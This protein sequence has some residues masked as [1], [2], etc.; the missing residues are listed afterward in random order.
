MSK[1][2]VTAKQL[3]D[4]PLILERVK[5][6]ALLAVALEARPCALLNIP[7]DLPEGEKLAFEVEHSCRDFYLRAVGEVDA[8]RKLERVREF[9]QKRREA[10]SRL[11]LGSPAYRLLIAWSKRL[12]LDTITT[13]VLPA[14]WELYL[15]KGL[16]Q[17]IRVRRS[18]AMRFR[19]RQKKRAIM[20]GK[21][22]PALFVEEFSPEYVLELGQLLGYPLCC[23]KRFIED[24][25]AQLTAEE[26]AS[27][28]LRRS[29][30]EEKEID[31]FAYPLK[32]FFPCS[33]SCQQA[34]AYGEGIHRRLSQALPEAGEQYRKLLVD[35]SLLV[36]RYPDIMRI[37]REKLKTRSLL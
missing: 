27:E 13:E 17:R 30:A 19:L 4:E 14:T 37:H 35:N 2:G 34:R 28:Q 15:C 11:I 5:L 16:H 8:Q 21:S 6:E 7:A 22:Y 23:V 36:E 25:T 32:D 12:G 20:L 10:F 3:L 24:R 9:T 31:L 29:R 33:P 1:Q 26:R 18:T